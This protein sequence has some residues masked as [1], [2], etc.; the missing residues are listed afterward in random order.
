VGGIVF[1]KF[2]VVFELLCDPSSRFAQNR[3]LA[4]PGS[5][6]EKNA[7][8]AFFRVITCDIDNGLNCKTRFV[9]ANPEGAARQRCG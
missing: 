6:C 4:H 5:T 7:G 9:E 8:R 3:R 1:D 2:L